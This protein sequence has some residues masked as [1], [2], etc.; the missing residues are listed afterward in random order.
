MTR[1]TLSG[2]LNALDGVAAPDGCITIMTTNYPENLDPALTRPGRVDYRLAFQYIGESTARKM[3]MRLYS[4]V[5]GHD[6][7]E[8]S[9][10]FA[11]KLP[12]RLISPAELQGY[13]LEH[14]GLP[15]L[16]VSELDLWIERTLKERWAQLDDTFKEKVAR[17][18][19][20]VDKVPSNDGSPC[21]DCTACRTS[22]S[23]R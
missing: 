15:E 19:D 8:L 6:I 9:H 22:S 1:I 14:M 2:L 23:L 21:V 7:Q 4:E 18:V 20:G 11:S 16:V 5:E 12:D 13:L 10:K 3:F 17:L